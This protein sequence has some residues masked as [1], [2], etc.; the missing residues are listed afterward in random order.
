MLS[1]MKYSV[2]KRDRQILFI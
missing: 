1:D 2:R